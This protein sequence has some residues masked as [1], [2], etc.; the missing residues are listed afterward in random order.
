MVVDEYKKTV[1]PDVTGQLHIY[2]HSGCEIVNKT[3][4]SQS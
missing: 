4:T 3:H 2:T 1:S